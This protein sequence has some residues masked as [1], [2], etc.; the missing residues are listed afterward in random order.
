ML[1]HG[2]VLEHGDCRLRPLVEADEANVLDLWNRDYVLGKLFS[3]K[4]SVKTYRRCFERYRDDPG[5]WHWAV[6]EKS[7][8]RFCGT[9]GCRLAEGDVEPYLLALIPGRT[10][11]ALVPLWLVFDFDL[12]GLNFE[13]L[14]YFTAIDNDKGKGIYGKLLPEKVG[15]PEPVTSRYGVKSLR[16]RWTCRRSVWA[17]HADYFR[18]LMAPFA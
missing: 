13:Q 5:S 16:E 7:T 12:M 10:F 14:H 2:V 6:E 18:D 4:T 3:A 1:N 17:A 11:P 8:G 15:E 9:I